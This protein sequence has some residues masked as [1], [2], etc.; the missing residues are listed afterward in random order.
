[1][2]SVLTDVGGMIRPRVGHV[3]QEPLCFVALDLVEKDVNNLD[4]F[5]DSTI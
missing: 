1:M 2:I 4:F 5:H 3:I